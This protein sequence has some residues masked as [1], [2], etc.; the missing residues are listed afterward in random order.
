[1]G[2]T[3]V[4]E[5]GYQISANKAFEELQE[6]VFEENTY[7]QPWEGNRHGHAA[8]LIESF[9]LMGLY[10]DLLVEMSAQQKADTFERLRNG[11]PPRDRVEAV[12]WSGRSGTKS[13]LDADEVEPMQR[14]EVTE[15]FGNPHPEI[16]L[17]REQESM[18]HAVASPIAQFIVGYEDGLPA[19]LFFFGRT[20]GDETA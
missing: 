15:L 6:K 11:I 10:Q 5:T 13:I 17:L 8:F 12:L 1:V 3:W 2:Y 18:L 4:Y 9:E 19:A 16:V 20:G 7:A 14:V